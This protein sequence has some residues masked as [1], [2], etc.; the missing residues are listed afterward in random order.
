MARN[1][2]RMRM[3]VKEKE[4]TV[5]NAMKVQKVMKVQ[6]DRTLHRTMGAGKVAGLWMLVILLSFCGLPNLAGVQKLQ[7]FFGPGTAKGAENEK[8]KVPL[9]VV[10]PL[11][12]GL[13]EKDEEGHYRGLVVDYLNEIAKYTGWTYEYVEGSADELLTG[14]LAG[15]YDLMGGA[16]YNQTLTDYYDYPKYSMGSSRAILLARQDDHSIKSYDLTSLNGKTIGV[17]E[18]AG[19]KI[20]RLKDF[21]SGNDIQ[22]QLKYYSAQDMA[23]EENL[24]RFLRNKEVDLLLGNDMET[25]TGFRIVTSFSAQPYYLVTTLGNTEILEGI[26]MAL[27]KILDS[28]PTFAEE[29]YAANFPDV[30][31]SDMQFTEEEMAYIGEK[32]TLLVAVMNDWHPLFCRDSDKA[33]HEGVLPELLEKISQFSGLE[34]SYVHVDSYQE[35]IEC[36]QNGEADILGAYFDSDESA[37]ALGLARTKPFVTMNNIVVKNKSASYPDV[38]L[39]GIILE[40]REMPSEVNAAEILTC[41]N[42]LEGLKLVNS[43]KADFIYGLASRLEPMIQEHHFSNLVPV[44]LTNNSEAI[45]FAIS[46]PVRPEL[47]TILNKS[48][49]SLRSDEV[50][51]ILDRNLVSIGSS[52]MRLSDMIYANPVAFVAVL[53]AFI[54]L[55][56]SVFLIIIRSKMKSAI[57]KT[58][59][60]RAEAESR[61]R[62]EFLSRMSHE[63]RTPMNAIIGLTELTDMQ[64]DLPPQVRD[65]L[66]K[67]RASSEYLLSLINDILDM[68]RIDSGKMTIEQEPFHIG[69][70]LDELETMMESQAKIRNLVFC[71]QRQVNHAWLLGDPLRLRQILLNLLSNAFKFTPAGGQVKLSVM[72]EESGEDSALYTFSVEDTG[73]GIDR[74]DQERIFEAFEQ[75][76]PNIS[77]SE[78]TGLGLSISCNLVNLMNGKL[79]IESQPEKG[80]RFYFT[81]RLPY[82]TPRDDEEKKRQ[83][84]E[85]QDLSNVKV[86]LAEDNELNAEIAIE[87]L[88]M[89]GIHTQWA[90]DGGEAVEYFKAS[91]S[92]EYQMILMDI[93]MPGKDGLEATREIRASD[94]EDASSIPIIAM[95]ANSFK[96]DVDAA[97][98][99]G[100]NSF[101]PKPVDSAQLYRIIGELIAPG[102][103]NRGKIKG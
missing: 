78:G 62:G 66:K 74:E 96:E 51:A 89:R 65:N 83:P 17:Y 94:H 39:T 34:V 24:Y 9:K 3:T 42:I 44:T 14:M 86:L 56:G 59:L 95:T 41:S 54:L 100:M 27:E 43:G 58:E 55:G 28:D 99:A 36:V 32:Q 13:S 81:I 84:P 7:G 47:L 87:L 60:E 93:R 57:M 37:A 25:N 1:E 70:T 97:I 52:Y 103:E 40:G 72:E 29:R 35:A 12:K 48:I 10:F 23:Q 16:Y 76:G 85:E 91:E 50:S 53:T 22:C 61:A 30:R 26:N 18:R 21:L 8:E 33:H 68:S 77:K 90:R 88:K 82:T 49:G 69:K 101:I 2:T 19:D 64:A 46:R 80:T 92:G 4:K 45:A 71:C 5:Q 73:I 63:I 75:L 38:D 6:N 31:I 20:E 98:E 79:K 11:V 67:L 102:D 15:E